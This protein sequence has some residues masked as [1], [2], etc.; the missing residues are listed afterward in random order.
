MRK[1]KK[2]NT[3]L[4]VSIGIVALLILFIG[5]TLIFG[6]DSDEVT[7]SDETGENNHDLNSNTGDISIDS[8]TSVNDEGNDAN[9]LS[10][11]NMNESTNENEANENEEN[12]SE[13]EENEIDENENE[14]EAENENELPESEDGEW[15]PIGTVQSEPFS[16]VY[17]KNHVNW[18][19]MTRALEYATGLTSEEMQVWYIG[20]GG[21]AQSAIGTVGKSEDKNQPYKVRLEWVENE[22]WMPVSVE[23][24]S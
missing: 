3:I 22:G 15:V 8:D 19:E 12:E 21:D 9:N 4:N 18:D 24:Q 11:S 23:K 14:N 20:N 10:E 13:N 6:G 5:G 16:A 1:K 7:I 2:M 17:E